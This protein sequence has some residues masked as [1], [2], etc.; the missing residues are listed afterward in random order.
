MTRFFKED[1][2]VLATHNPGKVREISE[3]LRPYNI[4]TKSAAD[5]DLPEP[6]EDG[7]SFRENAIIKAKF[8][9]KESGMPG[10][11]DDSGLCVHDLNDEPGIYSARWAGSEKNFGLAMKKIWERL[12]DIPQPWHA[13]FVCALALA[14]PDGHTESFEGKIFGEI[15]WPPRGEK[16]FGYDPIFV[17]VGETQTFAELDPIFKHSIS[18]RAEAF[19]MLVRSCFTPDRLVENGTV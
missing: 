5:L 3:L 16:G 9:A 7:A 17:P 4:I 19:D 15:T 6:I 10:L 14:W 2:L 13:H 11:S 12:K 18:H 8:T 1:V